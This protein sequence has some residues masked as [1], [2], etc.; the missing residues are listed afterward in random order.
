MVIMKGK[1]MKEMYKDNAANWRYGSKGEELGV[2]YSTDSIL[3]K[4]YD[5]LPNCVQYAMTMKE[6][7][8]QL[9]RELLSSI[10]RCSL[11]LDTLPT[12]N[13]IPVEW[14]KKWGKENWELECDYI[15]DTMLEDWE[16]RK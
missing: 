4:Y 12:V 10:D 2:S 8:E 1:K 5:L 15:L 13:A 11:K 9:K 6:I 16:K 3:T 14:I 7:E